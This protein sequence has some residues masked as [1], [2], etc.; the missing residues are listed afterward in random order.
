[1]TCYDKAS[2]KPLLNSWHWISY[3]LWTLSLFLTYP[4]FNKLP[5][6]WQKQTKSFIWFLFTCQANTFIM[7][8]HIQYSLCFFWY[9]CQFSRI[10][11]CEQIPQTKTPVKKFKNLVHG[12]RQVLIECLTKKW[13][14][15]IR[16]SHQLMVWLHNFCLLSCTSQGHPLNL[17]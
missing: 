14:N 8:N 15:T 13:D 7:Y 11:N 2:A 9:V 6:V 10:F 5:W 1:M 12:G 3:K 17:K 4:S 16:Q